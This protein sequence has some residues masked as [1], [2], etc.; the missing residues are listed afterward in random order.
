MS[1]S[2]DYRPFIPAPERNNI[3]GP[4]PRAHAQA[5]LQNPRAQD[6][7]ET[8]AKLGSAP[9]KGMTTDGRVQPGLFSL[10]AE[11]APTPAIVEAVN[12]LLQRL[13]PAQRSVTCFPVDSQ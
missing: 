10:Q 11:E 8:W 5:R 9:F 7:F 2:D 1:R 6:L 3:A 4:T 12:A 13:S